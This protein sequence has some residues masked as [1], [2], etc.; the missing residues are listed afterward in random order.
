MWEV[1]SGIWPDEKIMSQIALQVDLGSLVHRSKITGK[2]IPHHHL[3]E[4][5]PR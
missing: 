2:A 4:A 3:L 1:S 5:G